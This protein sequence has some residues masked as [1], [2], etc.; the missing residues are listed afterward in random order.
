MNEKIIESNYG[1]MIELG[2]IQTLKVMSLAPVGVYLNVPNNKRQDNILLPRKQVPENIKIDDDIEVFVYRDSEDRLIATIN[3]P[4]LTLYEVEMLKVISLTKIGAFLDWGLERDLLLPFK[5]QIG[6]VKEGNEYL[7][8]LYVD[9]TDRLCATM[10]VY[11]LLDNNSPYKEHD[12]VNGTVYSIKDDMG[13]FVAIDNKYH[14]LIPKNEIFNSYNIGDSI[15]G[16]VTKVREDGKLYIS[17]RA[18]AY[19]QMDK[20]VELI[21]EK[22]TSNNGKLNLN[23]KSKPDDIKKQ[24]NISKNGFKRAVGRLLKMDKIEITKEGIRLK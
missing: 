17:T 12:T 16:R 19:I 8:G 23:D 4:K 3:K 20:D 2:E 14:G 24:L 9:K 10:D 18:K 11:K 13:I 21:L 22:L 5:E 15:E 6:Q 1:S 7:V